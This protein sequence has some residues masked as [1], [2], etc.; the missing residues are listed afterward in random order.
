MHYSKYRNPWPKRI[1]WLTAIAILIGSTA[2]YYRIYPEKLPAWAADTVVGNK[3][4]TTQVYKWQDADGDW[5]V[6]DQP[7]PAGQDFEVQTYNRD[8]NIL[9]L[10]P[11]L[12]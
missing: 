6:S 7:P 2:A 10:P 12:K 11:A 1:F 9:P 5:H 4:Q 8:A 3:L